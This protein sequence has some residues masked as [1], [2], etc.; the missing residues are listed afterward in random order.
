MPS[1]ASD[2][3]DPPEELASL[4]SSVASAI[5][6]LDLATALLV[7]CRASLLELTERVGTVE[8]SKIVQDTFNTSIDWFSSDAPGLTAETRSRVASLLSGTDVPLRARGLALGLDAQCSDHLGSLIAERPTFE[9]S[10]GVPYFTP[11][12]DLT[13]IF[14]DFVGFTT[15]RDARPNVHDLDLTPHLSLGRDSQPLRVTVSTSAG[16]FLEQ[17]LVGRMLDLAAIRSNGSLLDFDMPD[18]SGQH[19]FPVKYFDSAL[20]A[21]RV[22]ALVAQAAEYNVTIAVLPELCHNEEARDEALSA[23]EAL[24][25]PPVLLAGSS[26]LV[27]DGHARNRATLMYPRFR[28]RVDQDKLAPV[29]VARSSKR[30]MGC[31]E[32]IDVGSELILHAGSTWT[33]AALTCADL[34]DPGVADVVVRLA[35]SIV[36]IASMTPKTD[37]FE[38][39]VHRLVDQCQSIVV[40]ANNPALWGQV[41]EGGELAGAHEA[42]AAVFGRPLADGP[43]QVLGGEQQPYGVVLLS[44]SDD[45]PFWLPQVGTIQADKVIDQS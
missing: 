27:A 21:K 16:V 24:G 13:K 17:A 45:S 2:T 12:Q 20:Q 1:D 7:Y 11:I 30:P 4:Q 40:L 15:S 8:G 26:H 29:T 38:A 33:L 31:V 5:D 18:F 19:F 32:G 34:L 14:P 41:T 36:L 23:I 42:P 35:P 9:L 25:A 10:A 44:A 28:I 6:V 43:V 37:A 39:A 22:T 3:P